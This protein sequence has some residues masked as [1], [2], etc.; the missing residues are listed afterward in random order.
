M[1]LLARP[2]LWRFPNVKLL[3]ALM[4]LLSATPFLSEF[5]NGPFVEACLL[6]LVLVMS[7]I[8]VGHD[9]AVL[10]AAGILLAPA[11]LGKWIDLLQPQRFPPHFFLGF[12]LAFIAFVIAILLRFILQTVEVDSD[13]LCA[14]ISAYLLLGLLWSVAY[15]LVAQISPA[16]FSFDQV[17]GFDNRMDSFN[18]FYFSF[19]SLSTIGAGGITANSKLA[20]TLMVM[21]SVTGPLYVAVLISRL[22]ALYARTSHSKV[23]NYRR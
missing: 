20:R 18:A 21:E 3:C 7:L 19:G 17:Q 1:A 23:S 13:V 16:S 12:E 6:T 11:I 14:G 8:A 9:R 4:L 10:T 22:V 15:L 2:G 5:S